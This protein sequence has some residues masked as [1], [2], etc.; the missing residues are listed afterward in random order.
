MVRLLVLSLPIVVFFFACGSETPKSNLPEGGFDTAR[1][2][3]DVEHLATEIG[4]R[5]SGS[6]AAAAAA[7]YIAAQFSE[8]RF[9][10]FRAN[11]TYEIDPNRPATVTVD[12]QDIAAVTAGGSM[13]GAAKEAAINVGAADGIAPNSIGGRIAVASR[14]G[15]T[16]REKYEAARIGGASALIILN[17]EPGELIAN[18]GRNVEFPV[19]TVSGESSAMVAAAASQGSELTVTVP[20][21]Q[22][23]AGTNL[24]ARSPTAHSC[25]FL[26]MANYDSAPGSPGEND[27][28]SGVAVMLELARQFIRLDKSKVPA[29]CFAAMDGGFSGGTG[30]ASYAS[31]LTPLSQPAAVID[32]HAVGAGGPITVF[33]ETTLMGDVG[34]IA[35]QFGIQFETTTAAPSDLDRF[36]GPGVSTLQIS[37]SGSEPASTI[38]PEKLREA[39]LLAGELM[40]RLGKITRR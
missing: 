6:Q 23:G 37:R 12:G 18:L 36:S 2:M 33:G 19:V 26:M 30:V 38:E 40:T 20:P 27:D 17:A 5:P 29:V 7:D 22:L 35:G 13:A 31:S 1:A 8:A 4:P 10:V 9:G 3:A 25:V 34:E 15:S 39:G 11:Y 21:A 14:G 28:A 24:V 16:F 32:L